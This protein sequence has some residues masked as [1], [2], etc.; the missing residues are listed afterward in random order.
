M[1]T[2]ALGIG[3]NSAIFTLVNAVLLRPLGY[4]DA[5]RL[6][7]IYEVIPQSGVARFEVSPPD[8]LDLVAHQR[9]FSAIG[10]Y[11]TRRSSSRERRAGASPG[12]RT[13]RLG[14]PILGVPRRREA[15]PA[16]EDQKPSQVAVI[17]ELCGPAFCGPRSVGGSG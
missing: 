10:A 9:S 1:L 3:A 6:M 4:H 17:S 12:G 11:R 15:V 14:L 8:Y 16:E 5:D 7:L 13:D 2:L